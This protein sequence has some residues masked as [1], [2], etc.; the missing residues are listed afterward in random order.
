MTSPVGGK[1]ESTQDRYDD[2]HSIGS[3]FGAEL[4]ENAVRKLLGNQV[5]NP[6]GSIVTGLA[7]TVVGILES[8]ANGILGIFKPGAS[9]GGIRDAIVAVMEPMESQVLDLG[10]RLNTLSTEV[11]EK[12]ETQGAPIQER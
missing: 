12:I 3:S 9:E 10:K 2:V 8:V 7:G 5:E 1:P 11:M 6:F 4:D